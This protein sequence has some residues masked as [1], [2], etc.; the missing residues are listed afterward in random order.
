MKTTDNKKQPP[1]PRSAQSDA[2]HLKN[3]GGAGGEALEWL[4]T[5]EGVL[6]YDPEDLLYNRPLRLWRVRNRHG[7]RIRYEL[8]GSVQ[9]STGRNAQRPRCQFEFKYKGKDIHLL[10]SHA[11][12]LAY[13]GFALSDRRHWVVDHINGNTLDDKLSNLQVISQRENCARSER[14]KVTLRLSPKENKRR[15]EERVAWMNERRLQ[16]M[17]IH[18]DADMIDIE[19]ELAVEMLERKAPL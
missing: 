7:V 3:R 14:L 9:K 16:L 12:M 1:L 11:T 19:F 4:P 18:P 17:A 6:M 10:R 8:K 2:S 13:T 5:W 15:R